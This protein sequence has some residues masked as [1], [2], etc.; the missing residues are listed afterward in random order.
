[1]TL[2]LTLSPELQK[3]LAVHAA[4][5]GLTPEEYATRLLEAHVPQSELTVDERRKKLAEAIDAWLND[6]DPDEQRETGEYLI[7]AL[8]ESRAGGRLL[9]PEDL[10]GITW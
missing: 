8:N 9:Y 5:R 3:R 10:K 6:D 2:A 4:E 1:M 7:R